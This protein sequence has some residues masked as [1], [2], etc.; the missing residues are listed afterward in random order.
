MVRLYLDWNVLAQMKN[1]QHQEL[2]DIL[3]NKDKFIKIFSTAHIGDIHSGY[4][5]T[6]ENEQQIRSDLEFLSQV[7]DDLCIYNNGKDITIEPYSPFNLFEQQKEPLPRAE[8][9]NLDELVSNPQLLAKASDYNQLLD[10]PLDGVLL[11]ALNDPVTAA[12]MQR[13]YPGL[14]ADMTYG[15]LIRISMEMFKSINEGE[16]Y[17]DLRDI[18]QKGLN[19]PRDQL[20]DAQQ[21]FQTIE[22]IYKGLPIDDGD[23]PFERP[24]KHA[25]EWFGR[26][27]N[28]YIQLDM[29]GY[30]EDKVSVGKGR[31]Q[32]FKNTTND[33]FHAA[34]A[35][36]C[37]FYV[38]N[39][40]RAYKKTNQVY[41]K[42]QVNTLVLK[43]VEFVTYYQEFLWINEPQTHL[44]A[45]LKILQKGNYAENE[46]ETHILKTFL[47]SQ[48]L[49]DHFTRAHILYTKETGRSLYF[50]S[51]D[52]P[53][54]G[55]WTFIKEIE[56]VMRQLNSFL[57]QDL[58]GFGELG[59]EDELDNWRG[60]R[61]RLDDH[62][63]IR[64]A[65]PNGWL[66]LYL[67]LL[68]EP[69]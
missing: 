3:S 50:L 49:F 55:R 48:F 25:P 4:S 9:F 8:P 51:K 26:I 5:G 67:D 35:S 40:K 30:Q 56:Q 62:T 14:R 38:T 22:N 46:D 53:T 32:T 47:L 11:E 16:A 28:A 65:F 34:F 54:N 15:D 1:G 13:F 41:E 18:A 66:Q 61:W 2:L 60:R 17:K 63:E 57:G 31:N 45:F 24:M 58:D 12:G 68:D 43:P 59:D 10:R 21:P 37:D 52:K 36:S 7:T 27:A 44:L 33:A 20:F 6:L 39:D 69:V 42:L 23:S 64:L 29:H 19:I